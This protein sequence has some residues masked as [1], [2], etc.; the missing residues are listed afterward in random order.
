MVKKDD[1][2][3]IIERDI[4]FE[5]SASDGVRL[6][7]SYYLALIKLSQSMKLNHLGFV[8]FD[9]PGQQQMKDIDLS[10][11]LQWASKNIFCERQMIVSTSETFPKVKDSVEEGGATIC[12]FDGFILQPLTQ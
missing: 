12:S 8:V 1:E 2:G 5:V 11:F 3:N 10:S 9:E 6:K 4:G 7:W